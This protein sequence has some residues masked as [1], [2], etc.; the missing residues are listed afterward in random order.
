MRAASLQLVQ[1]V[2]AVTAFT[3]CG[4]LSHPPNVSELTGT[5]S[6]SAESKTFLAKRK[7]Y[8]SIPDSVIE[9]RSDHTILIRDLPDCANDGFGEGQ[10]R[11]LTGDGTWRLEKERFVGYGLALDVRK[12]GSLKEG[13][14]CGPWIQIR[15]KS[16]PHELEITVGDPDSGES[17]KYK[18]KKS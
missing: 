10:G 11:F 7:G 9:L 1:F 15:H 14:Y 3:A 16:P 18:Q 12:G 2:I 13:I 5:Y 6:L 8:A 4:R 17:L